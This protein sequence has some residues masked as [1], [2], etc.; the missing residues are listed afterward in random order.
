VV[1]APSVPLTRDVGTTG[2][3]RTSLVVSEAGSLGVEV[4][5]LWEAGGLPGHRQV[6]VARR[7]GVA[8]HLQQVRPD[9]MQP[10]VPGDPLIGLE[11]PEQVEPCAGPRTM[12]TATAWFSATTGL[13]TIRSNSSNSPA[14]R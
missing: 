13:S 2:S 7:H 9:R 10:M 8:G 14:M 1:G 11:L 6:G 4:A 3:L 5:L 12:A